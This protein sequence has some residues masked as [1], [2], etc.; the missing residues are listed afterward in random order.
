VTEEVELLQRANGLASS[1][2]K[3]GL[4]LA[5]A[6]SR[7]P[8]TCGL[9]TMLARLISI[10]PGTWRREDVAFLDQALRAL[11]GIA[12][13]QLR[14][15]GAICR[16]G[17]PLA[18]HPAMTIL[19]AIAEAVGKVWWLNEP[20]LAPSGTSA[21]VTEADWDAK[22]CTILCRAQLSWLDSL[23]ERR[24]RM[25][26]AHGEASSQYLS[27]ESA[28]NQFKATLRGQHG[29]DPGLALTGGSRNWKVGGNSMPTS[30]EMVTAATE[31]AYGV[32]FIGSGRNPYPLYSGYAQ[33]S[34][35]L[36]FAPA[37]KA[38]MTMSTLNE[39]RPEEAAT[40]VGL[41]CRTFSV[42][43][44]IAANALGHDLMQL[45]SWE[46]DVDDLVVAP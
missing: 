36:W 13:V 42:G 2:S 35:E 41:A 10:P 24:G 44:E 5:D 38:A 15:F 23:A 34:I 45:G 40:I 33:G 43:F 4:H 27:A 20:L 19:R 30:S 6:P 14:G 31:Y 25:R 46:R 1:G 37:S 16:S 9:G 11:I 18:L 21:E 32:R 17:P 7:I 26:A 28:I 39:A 22:A 29:M 8:P 3:I 12:A